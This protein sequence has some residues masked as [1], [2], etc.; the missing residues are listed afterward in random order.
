MRRIWDPRGYQILHAGQILRVKFMIIGLT[1]E[2][3]GLWG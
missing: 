1:S 2:S 3:W